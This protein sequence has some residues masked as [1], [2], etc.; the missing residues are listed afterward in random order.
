MPLNVT[1]SQEEKVSSH[2]PWDGDF[3]VMLNS[4]VDPEEP[5]QAALGGKQ[6]LQGQHRGHSPREM[7]E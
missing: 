5:A 6:G 2:F 7:A 3:T 4:G 1:F